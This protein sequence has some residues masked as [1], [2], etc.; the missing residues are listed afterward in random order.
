MGIEY[1][2]LMF[3]ILGALFTFDARSTKRIEDQNVRIEKIIDITQKNSSDI[4]DILVWFKVQEEKI[5]NLDGDIKYIMD[6]NGHFPNRE[7]QKRKVTDKDDE[8]FTHKR[9]S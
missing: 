6:L 8:D 4:H 9:Q 7:L 3:G 2:G 5:D 1:V